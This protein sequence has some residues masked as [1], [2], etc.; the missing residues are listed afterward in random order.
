MQRYFFDYV[1]QGKP[2][3]DYIGQVL[4]TPQMAY[5]HAELIALDLAVMSEDWIGWLISVRTEMGREIFSLPV[6]SSC[7]AAA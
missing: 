4:S 3:Y 5:E 2:E 7:L 6:E 1:G